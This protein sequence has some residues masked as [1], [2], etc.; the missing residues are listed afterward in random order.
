MKVTVA[1][2]DDSQLY[3]EKTDNV[4]EEFTYTSPKSKKPLALKFYCSTNC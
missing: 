4:P 2:I 3:I 1:P